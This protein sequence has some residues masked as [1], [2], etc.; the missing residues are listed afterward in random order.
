VPEGA[1]RR[2]IVTVRTKELRDGQVVE[3]AES[4]LLAALRSIVGLRATWPIGVTLLALGAAGW[5]AGARFTAVGV[6]RGANQVFAALFGI[7]LGIPIPTREG[8]LIATLIAGVF[9]SRV[10]VAHRPFRYKRGK[11]DGEGKRAR[12]R[13]VL[14]PASHWLAWLL[15]IAIDIASTF[16]GIAA[17]TLAPQGVWPIFLE[18]AASRDYNGIASTVLTFAPEWALIAGWVLAWQRGKGE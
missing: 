11:A 4:G 15:I 10:E 8:L 2:C 1:E 18:I 5:L 3:E 7:D 13:W 12:G 9:F 17:L 6:P 16:V 14:A